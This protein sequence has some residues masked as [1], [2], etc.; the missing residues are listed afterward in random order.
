MNI[1]CPI[2]LEDDDNS[3]MI[4]ITAEE[5]RQ[6]GTSKFPNKDRS[7]LVLQGKKLTIY[8]SNSWGVSFVRIF[9]FCYMGNDNPAIEFSMNYFLFIQTIEIIIGLIACT[10]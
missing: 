6:M 3:T 8:G 4:C 7:Q 5:H 9:L 1:L 10:F 2:N